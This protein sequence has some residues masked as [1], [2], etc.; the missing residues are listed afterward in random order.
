MWKNVLEDKIKV[1]LPNIPITRT[2]PEIS[3]VVGD[4]LI[5]PTPEQNNDVLIQSTS[6]TD[7][8]V[9]I[10]TQT[11]HAEEFQSKD[12]PLMCDGVM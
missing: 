8:D 10:S 2:G 7:G 11:S 3:K 6:T 1:N 12:I 9:L 4:V 5:P